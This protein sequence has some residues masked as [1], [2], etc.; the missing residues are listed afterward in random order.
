MGISFA[1]AIPNPTGSKTAAVSRK[2]K[3]LWARITLLRP[4]KIQICAS[5][6]VF[7]GATFLILQ[8]LSLAPVARAIGRHALDIVFTTTG[9]LFETL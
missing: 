7:T 2:H 4:I 9:F 5:D 3:S 6:Q 1:Q 8:F